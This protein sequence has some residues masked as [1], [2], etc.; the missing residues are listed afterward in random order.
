MKAGSMSMH[1]RRVVRC[2]K[3]EGQTRMLLVSVHCGVVSRVYSN[4]RIMV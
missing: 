4:E 1:I 3:E 2:V